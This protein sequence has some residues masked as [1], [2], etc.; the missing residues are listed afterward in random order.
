[1]SYVHN[2]VLLGN[3]WLE[4]ADAFAELQAWLGAT[5]GG[6]QLVV[7]EKEVGGHKFLEA[8]VATAAFNYG[9]SREELLAKLHALGWPSDTAL[10]LAFCSQDDHGWTTDVVRSDET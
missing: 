9:P 3:C 5:C 1:V 10:T 8:M 6:Q 4:K 2:V 7:L